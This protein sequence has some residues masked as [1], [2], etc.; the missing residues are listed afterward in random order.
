MR[1]WW[2]F[3]KIH[4]TW[5]FT[6]AC[7]G[8]ILGLLLSVHDLAVY[9][10]AWQWIIVGIGLI[11]FAS[12]RQWRWLLLI[13]LTGGLII[14]L[15][16]GSL[17]NESRLVYRHMIG[18]TVTLTG[19]VSEDVE[20]GRGETVIR[21]GN[22]EMD[23]HKLP[24]T[25]W[26][27]ISRENS[28][29]RSDILTVRGRLSDGFGS[30]AASMYRAEI[31]KVS[32]PVPGDVALEV[33]QK[34]GDMVRLSVSDPAASLGMGYLTGERRSLPEELDN[35]LRTAGLT[36][37][38]VA[39]G[40]NL[41]ILIRFARRFFAQYSRFMTVF[42]SSILITCFVAVTGLSPSMSRAGLVAGLALAAWY[43]GR[44]FHPVTLLVFAAA[45]TGLFDPSY[46]WGN[47]GWQ[48][49]FAAFAG[50]MIL[51]PLLQ[52]YFFGPKKPG[53]LRQIL[54][55]TVSAQ[56]VTAP[57]LLHSFGQISNVAIIA[58]AL[59][60]PLVPLAMALTFMTGLVEWLS[61]GLASIVGQPTQWL[62]D[63]MVGVARYTS[64]L[65]WSITEMEIT[66]SMMAMLYAVIALACWWMWRATRYRLRD[67][68][69]V[70]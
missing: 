27:T 6:L 17:D 29:R 22:I 60:L 59:V 45:V 34:F 49:S 63:Y 58:N 35:A 69:I 50:V 16:R 39:S 31:I 10:A 33:R 3:T 2:I 28:I 61:E 25:L 5:H 24:A 4:P 65:S 67:S 13:S 54:G 44:K 41:T 14:G 43:F 62:L 56:I 48:L 53:V 52:V 21:L 36:H 46:V 40:Y 47:L 12:W 19:A 51:A 11:L 64:E 18:K 68:S 38:V 42:A 70:E 30:F 15:A 8:V 37:I 32:R 23:G 9:L 1:G 57:L 20:T 26:V 55:E 7:S 66:S